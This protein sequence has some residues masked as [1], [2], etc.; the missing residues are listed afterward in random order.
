MYGLST[1]SSCA[2]LSNDIETDISS[3]NVSQIPLPHTSVNNAHPIK[4]NRIIA[5]NYA[6]IVSDIILKS[7]RFYKPEIFKLRTHTTS[8]REIFY[9]DR[10]RNKTSKPLSARDSFLHKKKNVENIKSEVQEDI[11]ASILKILPPSSPGF[12]KVICD[13]FILSEKKNSE[14]S[15][16][17]A[18]YSE[19]S[20]ISEHIGSI[21]SINYKRDISYV[22]FDN[23][24]IDKQFDSI[25]LNLDKRVNSMKSL[26]V[27]LS[28]STNNENKYQKNHSEGSLISLETNLLKA[29]KDNE[30]L[31]LE[32]DNKDYIKK[33]QD[34]NSGD[35]IG[36]KN[37]SVESIKSLDSHLSSLNPTPL[38]GRSFCRIIVENEPVSSHF[39][40][41]YIITTIACILLLFY[42]I[43]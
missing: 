39:M 12:V 26:D 10:A 25:Y 19:E 4:R 43:E 21:H 35:K 5:K 6:K 22:N 17:I 8:G 16:P 30:C 31:D 36:F 32:K 24:Q 1:F 40:S 33:V 27:N 15:S 41:H 2:S 3:Q 18:N 7:D 13:Q 38:P 34:R 37:Y 42:V 20:L 14:N 11:R 28:N 9:P 23:Y 29:V